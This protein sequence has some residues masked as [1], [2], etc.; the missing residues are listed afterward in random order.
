MKRTSNRSIVRAMF[1]KAEAYWN[2][3]Y[4]WGIFFTGKSFGRHPQIVAYYKHRAWELQLT[5]SGGKA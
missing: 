2:R 3:D 5:D 1:P 4:G